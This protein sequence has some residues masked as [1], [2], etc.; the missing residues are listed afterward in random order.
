VNLSELSRQ[1][2]AELNV[3]DTSAIKPPSAAMP[4]NSK[5]TAKKEKKKSS[6]CY[7][8]AASQSTTAKLS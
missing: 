7:G 8:K 5:S 4:K 1:L 3:S 2:Q 6:I